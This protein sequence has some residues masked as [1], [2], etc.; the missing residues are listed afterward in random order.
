MEGSAFAMEKALRKITINDNISSV[1]SFFV[2]QAFYEGFDVSFYRW[3]FWCMRI[4]STSLKVPFLRLRAESVD[5][6][7]AILAEGKFSE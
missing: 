7:H 6:L 4:L 5:L 3:G 1:G 2:S